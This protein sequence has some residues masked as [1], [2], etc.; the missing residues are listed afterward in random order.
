MPNLA[1]DES[2]AVSRNN[3]ETIR[4]SDDATG[5]GFVIVS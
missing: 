2:D 3:V 5:R 4:K 1:S